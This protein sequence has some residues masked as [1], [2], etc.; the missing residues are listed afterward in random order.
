MTVRHIQPQDQLQLANVIRS[1][2]EE[3]DAPLVNTVYDD[4]RT[5]H[6]FDT[7]EGENAGY[8]VIVDKGIVLGGCGYY[9]T[10]GLPD[11]YAELVKFYLSPPARGLGYGSKL[12]GDSGHTATTIF[13]VKDLHP[14]KIVKYQPKYKQDFIRLN[15]EWIECFARIEPSDEKTFAHVDDIVANGGQIFLAIDEENEVVGCCALVSHPEKQ[16]HELAK[17]AVT[18]KA[19]GRGI[20][21]ML[22]ES[23]VDYARKH[24]VR[25][26]YLEGNTR[27]EA[28]IALYRKLGFR[29]IPAQFHNQRK[30][31][32]K[33]QGCLL[34]YHEY[35]IF[36]AFSHNI[37]WILPGK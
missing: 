34:S 28:S 23:L 7:L 4:P 36:I 10:E 26:I 11:G 32:C 30:A 13:M 9:P 27:L 8:W 29:E 12:F 5:E 2:F 14:I 15:R 37:A 1:V 21:R 33:Q 22:G 17:M 6:V 25:R 31:V 20:G 16:C 18:P 35:G 19:Q 24:G 3:Y